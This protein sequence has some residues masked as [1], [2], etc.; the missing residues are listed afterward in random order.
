MR[1]ILLDTLS[2][3]FKLILVEKVL[4]IDKASSFT[5][6]LLQYLFNT[7]LTFRVHFNKI[8]HALRITFGNRHRVSLLSAA[9]FIL[10]KTKKFS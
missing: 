6:L 3:Q 5:K 9:L 4:C 8:S 1:H 10:E 7:Q 2:T